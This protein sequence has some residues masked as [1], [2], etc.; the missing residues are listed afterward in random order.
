METVPEANIGL[1][2]MLEIEIQDDI[3]PD[4]IARLVTI[5]VEVAEKLGVEFD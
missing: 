4:A 1:L 5:G 3:R 2:D